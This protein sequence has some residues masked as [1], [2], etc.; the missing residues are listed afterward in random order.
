MQAIHYDTDGAESGVVELSEA[1]F[2]VEPSTAVIHQ[3]VV[4]R[5]ANR[6]QGTAAA[7]G[8][9]DVIGTTAKPFRQKKTGNARRGDLKS[10]IQRGGGVSGGPQPRDYTQ[11]MPKKQRRK[12]LLSALSIRA[13]RKSVV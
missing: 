5:L 13:D 7:K 6:R 2:D 1:V 3:A 9:G 10:N 8:R 11:K 12:A 4:A